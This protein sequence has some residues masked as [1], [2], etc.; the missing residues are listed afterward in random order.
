MSEMTY[1]L[2]DDLQVEADGPIRI[3]R[4][5]R[6]EQ[7]N[8][9]NHELHPGL[10]ALFPQL[11]A[12]PDARVAVHHRQRPGVLGRRRLRLHRRAR[13]ATP[14]CAA[15]RLDRRP[16]DRHRHGRVPRAGRGRG[17]RAGRRARLQ[18]RGAVRH[19]LHGRERPPR[20]PPRDGRPR[21]RRRR[22]GHLAAAHQPAAGQGVRA[23]RRPHPRRSGR[24]QIGLVNHVC[25]DDEVLDA[26]PGLRPPHRQ[27][28]PSG[29][30]R[31]PS[32]SSTCTSSGRCWP[33]STSPSPPRTGRSPRPSCGPTSTGCCPARPDRKP[34]ERSHVDFELD[35]EQLEL[36]R[37]RAGHRR[38]GVPAGAGAGGR[39]RRRRRLR[40]CGRRS[41]GST[42]RA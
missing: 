2:P 18:P 37:R 9:T 23:D 12:D 33:R 28:A 13:R 14:S 31:T 6:P 10:A 17:Q 21:R 15:R 24:P 1:D 42:G 35:D 38:A 8:A 4:L 25:P 22:T 3:V 39:G 36:Q 29:P 20:R 41:S 19:R 5:N 40:R 16:P 11:D 27:A 26:G 32:A 7:L 34:K 30:P